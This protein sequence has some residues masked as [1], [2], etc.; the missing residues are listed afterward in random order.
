MNDDL[1]PA[2]DLLADRFQRKVDASHER[3]RLDPHQGVSGAIGVRGRE[4]PAVSGVHRLQHVERF[5]TTNFADHDP[6]GAHPQ[7][8]A[9]ERA[10]VDRTGPLNACGASFE[11]DDVRLRK[12]E[13]G[14]I[15]DRDDA[16]VFAYGERK[17]VPPETR[18]LRRCATTRMR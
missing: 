17:S 16:F 9:Q 11:G 13:L 18:M 6:I 15:L 2:T 10:Y 7:R 8:G 12:T 14:G 5:S 4:R 1:D 3:H